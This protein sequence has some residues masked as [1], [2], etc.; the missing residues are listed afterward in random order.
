MS[1]RLWIACVLLSLGC[2]ADRVT[3]ANF[4][5]IQPGMTRAE[6]EAILGPA[7]QNYQQGIL[8]W[9]SG[10]QRIITV[11]LDDRGRV[12]KLDMEGLR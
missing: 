11:I 8:T 12:D 7:R 5:K 9:S 1:R 6:V 10:E 2:Q 3:L 4:E